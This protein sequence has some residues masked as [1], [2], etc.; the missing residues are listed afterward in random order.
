VRVDA[1]KNGPLS[2]YLRA[3][4]RQL[5]ISE[6][7]V[8]VIAVLAEI[9]PEIADLMKG[10]DVRFGIRRAKTLDDAQAGFL[11]KKFLLSSSYE[12]PTKGV[13]ATG[14]A[15]STEVSLEAAAEVKEEATADNAAPAKAKLLR[16]VKSVKGAEEGAA[17]VLVFPYPG[18]AATGKSSIDQRHW[19]KFNS[20]QFIGKWLR[21]CASIASGKEGGVSAHMRIFNYVAVTKPIIDEMYL[22]VGKR[23]RYNSTLEMYHDIEAL[24]GGAFLGGRLDDGALNV[25]PLGSL[26]LGEEVD[27]GD[28]WR[29]AY[30]ILESAALQQQIDQVLLEERPAV[31]VF[32]DVSWGLSAL[33]DLHQ[34][35]DT[36]KT[37]VM[38]LAARDAKKRGADVPEKGNITAGEFV[39][40]LNVAGGLATA[41]ERKRLYE[42]DDSELTDKDSKKKSKMDGCGGKGKEA[43]AD[44]LAAA[45]V[46]VA[47]REVDADKENQW[48]NA[49]ADGSA[50]AGVPI[51]GRVVDADK[52][53]QWRNAVA[54]GKA[55]AGVPIAGRVVDA[56]KEKQWRRKQK[57]G[58]SQTSQRAVTAHLKGKF[59]YRVTMSH[60][61]T[62]TQ[63]F[64]DIA[65]NRDDT[66]AFAFCVYP[67]TL[68]GL[69]YK[70]LSLDPGDKRDKLTRL[71][72]PTSSACVD[73]RQSPVVSSDDRTTFT[74]FQYERFTELKKKGFSWC[75]DRVLVTPQMIEDANRTT[76]TPS[77]K[78]MRRAPSPGSSGKSPAGCL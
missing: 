14:C 23:A 68:D 17:P 10:V 64:V 63:C 54:D 36:K 61:E 4:K 29:Q 41:V 59:P 52:E 21:T 53:K 7:V 42:T 43:H 56:D 13:Y 33:H 19:D 6:R 20:E 51:A 70:K 8:V 18:L 76:R 66:N 1:D 34:L 47:G 3:K 48:R 35:M 74:D 32:K 49:V 26:L 62:E 40:W 69:L 9:C 57:A 39:R 22:H 15:V 45:G 65:A 12:K 58:F 72:L 24:L 75:V 27:G 38:V 60:V 37:T 71:I 31:T 25:Y 73:P 30:A 50:A 55:A 5:N 2:V 28:R 16:F 46:P 78:A 77:R 67:G 11:P 44:G